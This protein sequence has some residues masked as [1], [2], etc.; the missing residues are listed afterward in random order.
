MIFFIKQNKKNYLFV[1]TGNSWLEIL[2][3]Q[4]PNKKK[5]NAHDFI[6]GN[7]VQQGDMFI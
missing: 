7:F 2:E 4:Y 5:L 1:K 3:I 6:N